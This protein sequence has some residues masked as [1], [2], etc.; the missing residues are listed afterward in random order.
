MKDTDFITASS[1]IRTLE[2]RLLTKSKLENLVS[3]NHFP[4]LLKG[5]SQG[6]DYNLVTVSNLEQAERILK[7]EWNRVCEQMLKVSPHKEVVQI[8]LLPYDFHTLRQSMKVEL[9]KSDLIKDLPEEMKKIRLEAETL[10]ESNQ[11]KEAFLDRKMFDSMVKLSQELDSDLIN[12]QVQMKI[13]FYNIKTMLRAREMKKESSFF[14][15]CYVNGGRLTKEVFLNNYSVPFSAVTSSFANKYCNT[16]IQKGLEGYESN[17]NFSDLE[18][19][20]QN[21]LINHLK[22]AKLISYGAEIIYAYLMAK[23]NELRQIR[24]LLTCK[25]KNISNGILIRKLGESYV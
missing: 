2:N 24:L 16:E 12:E 4:D 8:M 14:E 20:L 3:I 11:I 1:Y 9:V 18:I 23:E 19:L 5:L 25:L 15:S 21:A 6:T 7:E 22:K 17:H 10:S 13:D